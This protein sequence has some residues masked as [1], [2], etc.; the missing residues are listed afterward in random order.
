M[1]PSHYA[2]VPANVAKAIVEKRS[3]DKAA[4]AA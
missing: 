4:V 3:A 2:E 1:E